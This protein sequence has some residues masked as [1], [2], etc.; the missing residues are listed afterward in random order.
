[1]DFYIRYKLCSCFFLFLTI[2]PNI[3]GGQLLDSQF[4]YSP[5]FAYQTINNYPQKGRE[6]YAKETV[7]ID[8][9]FPIIYSLLFA[10]ILRLLLKSRSVSRKQVTDPSQVYW[11]NF[12]FFP[13]VV[14][15]FDLLENLSI[16]TMLKLYPKKLEILAQCASFF[17][18]VKLILFIF[19][20]GSILGL[21]LCLLV[22]NTDS[23]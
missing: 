11:S 19:T 20:L 1:M 8:F 16:F 4:L 14:M 3:V 22:H 10:S 12:Y 9:I 13:F 15:V 21:W 17:T 23:T 6:F 7:T 5:D 18:S 2:I